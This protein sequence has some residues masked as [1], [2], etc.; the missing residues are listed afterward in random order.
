MSPEMAGSGIHE[1]SEYTGKGLMSF[2]FRSLYQN[3][4][5]Y[6][7]GYENFVMV[8]SSSSIS[9]PQTG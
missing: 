1:T 8:F 5:I 2:A 7:P 9:W 3:E 4:T 6:F